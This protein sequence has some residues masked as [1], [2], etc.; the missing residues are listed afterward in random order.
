M[1]APSSRFIAEKLLE[2][3]ENKSPESS[4]WLMSSVNRL[5]VDNP[6]MSLRDFLGLIERLNIQTL[7]SYEQQKLIK[8]K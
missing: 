4:F 6:N 7:S 8:S 1:S 5:L 2:Q 3:I